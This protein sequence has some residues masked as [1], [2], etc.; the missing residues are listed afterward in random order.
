MAEMAEMAQIL[1]G[2][3]DWYTGIDKGLGNSKVL[4]LLIV[5][6]V[7]NSQTT[8]MHVLINL[9]MSRRE[10][11]STCLAQLKELANYE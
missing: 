2:L 9:S 7:T 10:H 3:T 8:L 1:K 6:V 11:R 5:F 4:I